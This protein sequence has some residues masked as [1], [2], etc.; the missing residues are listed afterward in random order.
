MLAIKSNAPVL[1]QTRPDGLTES[2]ISVHKPSD[3]Y[4]PECYTIIQPLGT[5]PQ[6][7]LVTSSR[8]CTPDDVAVRDRITV[9]GSVVTTTQMEFDAAYAIR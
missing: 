4:E 1:G 3:S 9:A 5:Y 8:S 6:H 2:G 7:D